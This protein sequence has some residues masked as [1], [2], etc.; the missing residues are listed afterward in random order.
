MHWFLNVVPDRTEI[1]DGKFMATVVYGEGVLVLNSI[2][3]W[4]DTTAK[5]CVLK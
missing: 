2:L 4:I 3:M 5:F 1:V